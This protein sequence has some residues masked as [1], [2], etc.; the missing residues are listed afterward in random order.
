MSF[1]STKKQTQ[2]LD[3]GNVQ[4]E[5]IATNQQATAIPLAC[6]TNKVALRWICP[7]RNQ[8]TRP[9]PVTRPGKK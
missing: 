7:A 6:G 8:F 9:A 4:P 3:T 1:G 2:K 5:D